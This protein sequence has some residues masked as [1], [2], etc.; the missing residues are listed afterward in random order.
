MNSVNIGLI[1]A[2][3][4]GCGVYKTISENTDIIEK[5]TG[6]KLRIKKVA[7]LDIKRKRPVR[8]PKKLLPPTRA[9]L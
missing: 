3:T 7:D 6:I 1:G 4:I 9:N 5:R 2:G 8:I